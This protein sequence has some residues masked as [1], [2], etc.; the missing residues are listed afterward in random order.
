M[1][2]HIFAFLPAAL[3]AAC[4]PPPPSQ[5]QEEGSYDLV[6]VGEGF[7]SRVG[8]MVP[9]RLARAE[10]GFVE[11]SGA[12]IVDEDGGFNERVSCG[13]EGAVSYE[14][15]WYVRAELGG[16]C[17]DANKAW[18]EPVS[19]TNQDVEV[20]ATPDRSPDPDGCEPF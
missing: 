7:T 5:C 1:N 10:D 15:F 6:F 14:F 2:R 12:A 11:A 19:P 17:E 16:E 3:L 8:D 20:L 13:L 4:E 9:F 18:L